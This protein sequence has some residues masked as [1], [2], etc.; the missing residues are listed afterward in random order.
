MTAMPPAR[1]L[2]QFPVAE[3]SRRQRYLRRWDS[4]KAERSGWIDHWRDIA[5]NTRPRSFRYLANDRT[6]AGTKKNQ[7]IING[8]PIWALRTLAAGMMAGITSPSRPW[9]RFTSGDPTLSDSQ[10]AKEYLGALEEKVREALQKS[11]I[12]NALHQ[13]YSDLGGIGTSTLYIEEDS[14]DVMR[15][16]VFPVGQYCLANSAR[17]AVDTVYRELSMTVG[18]LVEQFGEAKCSDGVREKYSRGQINDW[19][20]VLHIIEPNRKFI[21]GKL[22]PVGKKFA[23]C[24]MERAGSDDLGF[25]RESGYEE[26]PIMAPR[27]ETTGED[28]Y[29]SSPGMDALGDCKALQ[30]AEK[31]KAQAIDKVVTPPMVG[32][33]ELANRKISLLPGDTTYLGNMSAGSRFMPAYEVNPNAV[34]T[35]GM[36]IRENEIRIDRAFFADLWL[37][38]SQSDG[39]KTATEIVERREEKLLQLGPVMERLQD[40]LLEPL[41]SRVFAILQRKQLLP[42][43]PEELQ[44]REVRVEYISI[45]AQA[46]KL[47]GTTGIERVTGYVGNLA[48]VAGPSA[49]DKLDID[50]AIDEYATMNGVPPDMIRSDEDVA[51]MREQ[52]AQAQQKQ[53]QLEQAQVAAATAKDLSQADTEGENGLT[54]MLRGLGAA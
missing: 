50:Q 20:E 52:R 5:E 19:V 38:L 11:N 16:Y 7:K 45:M 8:K 26:F 35:I 43:P 44:G 46:Q 41:I 47:L 12:Y 40:E 4:L 54:T 14:E 21:A 17:H 37:M 33:A 18:Q 39:V 9:F 36:E 10:A 49:L 51:A 31:R 30:L 1:T 23:S 13:V 22:G 3:V 48:A 24:W 15:A 25:L 34:A 2:K 6:R 27:W 28:I 29:G 32:P 42:P 53:A